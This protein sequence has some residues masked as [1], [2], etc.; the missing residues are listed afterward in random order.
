[1]GFGHM[2]EPGNR[3]ISRSEPVLAS[4]LGS[5]GHQRVPVFLRYIT[6]PSCAIG[7]GGLQSLLINAPFSPVL[8]HVL[9][10]P[11]G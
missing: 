8:R 10:C 1:M 6:T 3:V 7:G 4:G 11:F 9:G 2:N 5:V